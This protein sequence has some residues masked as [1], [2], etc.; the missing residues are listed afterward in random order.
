MKFW[1]SVF[2]I[3]FLVGVFLSQTVS[4]APQPN[5]MPLKKSHS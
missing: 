3:L 2:F 5:N 1:T 4:A